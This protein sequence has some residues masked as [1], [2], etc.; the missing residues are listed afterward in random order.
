M[1]D[2]RFALRMLVKNRTFT[3]VAILSLAIGIGANSAMFSFADGLLLRPLPVRKP[4]DVVTVEG[5]TVNLNRAGFGGGN[6]SF[7]DYVDYRDR[8]KSFAGLIAYTMVPFGFSPRP[9]AL[10][11]VKYGLLVSGNLFQAMG[12][13]PILGRDFRLDEDQEPGR[14]AVV[15]LGYDFWQSQ[16]KGDRDVIDRVIRL[17]GLDFTV[18]GVAPEKFT[19]LDQYFRNALFVPIHMS[20]RLAGNPKHN[21]LE[22]RD[23]RALSVKGRLNPGVGI[24]QAQAELRALATNLAQTYPETNHDQTVAVRTELQTR[25]DRSGPDAALVAMLMGLSS[26]VLLVACANVASLLLSR[27]RARSREMAVRL[28]IGAGRARLV[29]QLLTESLFI[30]LAGGALSLAVA[31]LGL[32]LVQRIQVPTDMPLSLTFKLDGRV[33]LFSLAVSLA[34][35]LFFGLAPALQ[36]SRT[37]LVPA[38]KALDADSSGKKRLWGR[39]LLV[40]GQ[41]A[42]SLVLL[43][44]TAMMYR[45][46]SMALDGGPGFRTTHLLMMSFDPSLVKFSEARTQQFYKQI[47][48]RAV[49]LPGVKSAALTEVIPMMPNQDSTE[50]VPEGD[51]L[52]KGQANVTILSD[53]VTPPYFDTMGIGILQGRGFQDTDTAASTKVAVINENLAKKYWPNQDPIG[54]RF[55][56]KDSKGDW[57]QVVGVATNVKYIFITEPPMEYFYM[58]L[59]QHPQPHMTLVAESMGDAA[60]LATEIREMVRGIDSNQ[61]IY[62]VRTMEDFYAKRAVD[63]PN[64]I[65]QAVGAL[66]LMGLLLAMVG[67]YALVANSVSRRMREFGIRIAIGANRGQVVGLVLRQGFWLAMAGI[68]IGLILSLGAARGLKAA[69]ITSQSDPMA[70]IVV[71]P[72]LLLIT[73]LAA[74]VPALRASRVDPL[75]ALRDE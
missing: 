73:M 6:L 4:S 21:L 16:F 62:G 28:A 67:L 72:L 50:I 52:P 60:G 44:V 71:P 1:Q 61:P 23:N 64:L 45:G 8:N 29:R 37:D 33:L 24:E 30:G 65:L 14:D 66:G 10:P 32:V 9:E 46:F 42:L 35:V 51:H 75:T 57:V 54:R 53:I 26:L 11:E 22:G 36:T 39:N 43:V 41:V 38:L 55:Q 49:T 2:I 3:L 5:T 17:N 31:R 20:P 69:F 70:M 63:T 48:D 25:I 68:G 47:S 7:R 74:Y 59:T 12:V 19:G 27:A 13:Q 40:V 18:V 58:P 34:S 15:I 56:L